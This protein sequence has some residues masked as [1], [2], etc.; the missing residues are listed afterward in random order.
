MRIIPELS[1]TEKDKQ[2]V[3]NNKFENFTPKEA[4]QWVED[5]VNDWIDVKQAIKHLAM[6]L[7]Y[8]WRRK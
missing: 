6:L 2:D 8:L 7:V 3:I 4:G 5:N 1:Q